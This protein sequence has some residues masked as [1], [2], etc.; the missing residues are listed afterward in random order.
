MKKYF[1][2][3]TKVL[4]DIWAFDIYKKIFQVPTNTEKQALT[5]AGLGIKRIQFDLEEN[6]NTVINKICSDIVKEDGETEGF[7]K[8][9]DCGGFEILQC[10]PNSR[11][12]VVI[13]SSLAARFFNPVMQQ[14]VSQR[15]EKCI[16]CQW[17]TSQG[18]SCTPLV[19][20]SWDICWWLRTWWLATH[21]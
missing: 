10:L 4:H 3:W 20:F 9:R 17:S 12:L 16:V 8:L 7:P 1:Q 19:M 21:I 5:E 18:S 6:E 13:D 2:T 14:K 15:M 11:D